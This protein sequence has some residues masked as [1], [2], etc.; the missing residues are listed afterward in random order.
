M[1]KQRFQLWPSFLEPLIA[2]G[3]SSAIEH[4]QR[5]R[6]SSLG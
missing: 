1:L 5:V 2:G 4:H 6:Q 3:D